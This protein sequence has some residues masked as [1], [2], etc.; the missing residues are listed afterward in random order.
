MFLS[1]QFAHLVEGVDHRHAGQ[2]GPDGGGDEQ[3]FHETQHGASDRQD[4][5][6]QIEDKQCRVAHAKLLLSRNEAPT[7]AAEAII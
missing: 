4:E 7:R 2:K 3:L 6:H 1:E 5:E